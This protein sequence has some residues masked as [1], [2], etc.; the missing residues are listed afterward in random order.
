MCTSTKQQLSAL[1]SV[2]PGQDQGSYLN[3]GTNACDRISILQSMNIRFLV[4]ARN[5]CIII[6]C[7]AVNPSVLFSKSSCRRSIYDADALNG[8]RTSSSLECLFDIQC[9]F[10]SYV[11]MS[12]KCVL[13]QSNS[14]VPSTASS[15]ARTRDL[16]SMTAQ[17]LAI[18]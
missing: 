7:N 10:C 2:I 18:E 9:L 16:I 1:D 6:L 5:D 8:K 15:L 3:D 12:F 14:S 13:L 4:L 11:L 17:M